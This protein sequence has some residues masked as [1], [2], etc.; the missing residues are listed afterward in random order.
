MLIERSLRAAKAPGTDEVFCGCSLIHQPTCKGYCYSHF[1]TE[2]EARTQKGE[3]CRQVSQVISK[4]WSLDAL[5]AVSAPS[6]C[7][8]QGTCP[9]TCRHSPPCQRAP[10]C[11]LLSRANRVHCF[12]SELPSRQLRI[13][14][15][16]LIF[17]FRELLNSCQLREILPADE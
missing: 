13:V 9:H 12:P 10:P 3:L 15:G 1:T 7:A 6:P 4:W 5:G 14:S 16:R 8:S 11:F 2:E 17:A